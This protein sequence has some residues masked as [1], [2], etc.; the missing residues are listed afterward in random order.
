MFHIDDN[1][2][3]IVPRSMH[4]A[5]KLATSI[6]RSKL[7]TKTF[8]GLY[9]DE[10]GSDHVHSAALERFV[11]RDD[12]FAIDK[13]RAMGYLNRRA[14]TMHTLDPF[15]VFVNPLMLLEM[16]DREYDEGQLQGIGVEDWPDLITPLR[17]AWHSEETQVPAGANRRYNSLAFAHQ[18]HAKDRQDARA[19]GASECG[20]CMAQL[21]QSGDSSTGRSRPEQP[22]VKKIKL[23]KIGKKKPRPAIC[24]CTKRMLL[25][26]R[27]S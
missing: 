9:K 17:S 2:A 4:V 16:K 19:T 20:N 6:I 22:P 27:C 10:D 11:E 23:E 8:C 25:C 12:V 24:L 13:I 5:I 15:R 18:L 7:H 3:A 26:S 14:I 1:V 21:Q